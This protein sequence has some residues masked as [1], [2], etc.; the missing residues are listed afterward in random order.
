MIHVTE[1]TDVQ[2][3]ALLS[4]IDHSRTSCSDTNICNGDIT[5]DRQPRCIRCALLNL[6]DTRLG[7]PNHLLVLDAT[8]VY[9]H[10]QEAEIN[11]MTAR[12]K[13]LGFVVQKKSEW[14]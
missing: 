2:I 13:E 9:Q 10:P 12:L 1:L 8:V 3:D 7:Y 11:T 5:D 6:K 14:L 4:L